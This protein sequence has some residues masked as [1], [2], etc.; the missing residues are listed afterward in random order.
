MLPFFIPAFAQKRFKKSRLQNAQPMQYAKFL[1]K[2][3]C[4][5]ASIGV[6]VFFICALINWQLDPYK[7]EPFV[8][9]MFPVMWSVMTWLACYVWA[10]LDDSVEHLSDEP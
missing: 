1:L 5:T 9:W 8:K 10:Q 7:W 6:A 4:L 3:I 2:L